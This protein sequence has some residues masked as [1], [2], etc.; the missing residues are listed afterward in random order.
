[1]KLLYS[2]ANSGDLVHHFAAVDLGLTETDDRAP[3]RA[4]GPVVRVEAPAGGPVWIVTDADLARTVLTD[5]RIVKDPASAPPHWDPQRAGLEQTAAEQPSLTTLDG[6]GH[7]ELR[8]AHAPLLSAKRVREN[9]DRVR[10]TARRLLAELPREVDLMADFTTRYPLT[11]LLDL[12]GIPPVHVDRAA[13]ACRL[14]VGG[15]PATAIAELAAVAEHGVDGAGL[16]AELRDRVPPGTTRADLRYH[17]FSLIFAG[18]LTTDA[19]LGRTVAHA[20]TDRPSAS[21]EADFVRD[22]LRR[23]PPAPYSLWRFTATAIELA[24]E[25]LPA[26]S[27]VLVDIAAVN[28]D[29]TRDDDLTF[30]AG[31]HF[32]IGAQLALLELRAVVAVLRDD[33]PDARLAVPLADLRHT[34]PGGIMGSRLTALPVILE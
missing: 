17:L 13:A 8:R 25:H 34:G 10:A 30:G 11:V 33:Y 28:A 29:P 1:M 26:H 21:A 7:A 20:L 3:G 5:P 14:L 32:C 6:P 12:L 16:A 4:D 2:E 18:Q 23:H 9:A 19:A 27:P 15:D 22:T 31:P 24:G